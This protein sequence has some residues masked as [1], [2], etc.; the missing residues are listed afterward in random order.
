AVAALL[1]VIAIG[2]SVGVVHLHQAL[3]ESE[4]N[5]ERARQAERDTEVEL[6]DT[7]LARARATCLSQRP[8]Q[9]FES[10]ATL[11]E[12]TRRARRLG[13]PPESFANLRNAAIFALAVP[14]LHVEQTWAGFPEGSAAVDFADDLAL[15]ARADSQ[16][17]CEVRQVAGD[18]LLHFL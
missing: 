17:N 18:E 4:Q 11:T 6:I 7:L 8:G 16:G 10:L 14:D 9:R 5:L 1:L 13:L 12:A 3:A 2:A 15:Y